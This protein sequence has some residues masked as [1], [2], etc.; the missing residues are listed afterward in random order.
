MYAIG[1]V[2]EKDLLNI[3]REFEKLP[4]KIYEKKRPKHD[5][6]ERYF[7]LERCPAKCMMRADTLNLHRY[8]VRTEMTAPSS[9]VCST[10]KD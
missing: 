4:N 6:T 3:I 1:N 2:S 5:P 7:Y 8:P 9:H 10:Y